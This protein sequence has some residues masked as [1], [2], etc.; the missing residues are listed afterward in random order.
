MRVFLSAFLFHIFKD[1]H[2]LAHTRE[3]S[4]FLFLDSVFRTSRIESNDLFSKVPL[5]KVV[6][7]PEMF[8]ESSLYLTFSL[9]SSHPLSTL[10]N[11]QTSNKMSENVT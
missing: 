8:V 6:Q 11:S 7:T 1:R 9:N 2:S 3:I 4:C 10:K 5:I